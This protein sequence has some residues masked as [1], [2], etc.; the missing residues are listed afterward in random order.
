MMKLKWPALELEL[1]VDGTSPSWNAVMTQTENWLYTPWLNAIETT[2]WLT[3]FIL[4]SSCIA[5]NMSWLNL[6]YNDNP[7]LP[8]V[9]HVLPR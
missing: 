8:R 3:T 7:L 9:N 4:K 5:H 1:H 2:N 6:F